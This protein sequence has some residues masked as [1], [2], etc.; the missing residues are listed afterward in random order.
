MARGGIEPPPS[1]CK[2]GGLPLAYRAV[3]E[4]HIEDF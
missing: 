4:Q 1:R 2:R 3:N